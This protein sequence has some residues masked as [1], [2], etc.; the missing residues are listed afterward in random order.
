LVL[1]MSRPGLA[2]LL[3]GLSSHLHLPFIW[4]FTSHSSRRR[5]VLTTQSLLPCHHLQYSG[6]FLIV[7]Y[8]GAQLLK[9][10]VLF[11]KGLF[12][13]LTFELHWPPGKTWSS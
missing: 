8:S 11:S 4:Y 9:A 5:W 10:T 6:V 13:G 3:T 1:T 2:Q 12:S 7:F